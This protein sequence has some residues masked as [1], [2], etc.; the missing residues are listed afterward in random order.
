VIRERDS[1]GRASEEG[2]PEETKGGDGV[3]KHGDK[4]GKVKSVKRCEREGGEGEL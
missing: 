4:V 2:D 3:E 1:K